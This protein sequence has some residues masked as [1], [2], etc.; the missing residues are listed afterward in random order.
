MTATRLPT[1][2]PDFYDLAM[3]GDDEPAMLPL[4]TS[5]WLE[6]YRQAS[7]L[8]P[9]SHPVYD[10]GCGTGRFAEQLRRRGH[11]EYHGVDFSPLAV[12]E[13]HKYVPLI[14]ADT[15]WDASFEVADLRE[16]QPSD[17]V[18]GN[19]IFTCLETLEHLED[20]IGLIQRVPPGHEFI[21]SVPNYGGAAHLR[22]FVRVSEAFDRY[23]DLLT[24][25]AWIRIGEGPRHFIH[26]YRSVRRGD[27]W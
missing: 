9:A 24:F 4:E 13:C 19:A 1:T 21:F 18:A 20:D 16:W 3:T 2:E 25:S 5:P 6:L 22:K 8:I 15:A 14:D 17:Y 12:E 7:W 23:A 11:G 27:S 26:L 10:L